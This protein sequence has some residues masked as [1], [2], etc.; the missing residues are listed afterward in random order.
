MAPTGES[1]VLWPQVGRI[2]RDSVGDAIF[3]W[4]LMS[5]L[6]RW[7]PEEMTVAKRTSYSLCL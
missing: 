3:G 5:S 7:E 1:E 4:M 6:P 2:V